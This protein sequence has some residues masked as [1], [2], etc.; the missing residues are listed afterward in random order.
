MS[1]S[2]EPPAEQNTDALAPLLSD[3]LARAQGE[4]KQ[5]RS[6]PEA[7]Y[8]L[9][10]HAGFTFRDAASIVPYLA[11]L[12]ISDCYA[13]PF[14]KAAPGS[15]HG[16]DIT[17][18][19]SLNPEIGTA[20]DLAEL[21]NAL[22][23]HGMGMLLDTVPNHMGILGN[24]NAWWND[25][26]ENGHASP[27]AS[28][29]DIDWS[30]PVRPE[31]RDKVLLALLG[32]SYGE[33]LERGELRVAR[34]GG[35]FHVRYHEHRFPLDPAT[36]GEIL[37]P[38]LEP[39]IAQLGPDHAAVQEIQSVLTAIGHLPRHTEASAG[40]AAERLR[41]KE[42]IKRRLA[43]LIGDHPEIEAAITAALDKLNG[44][45]GSPSSFDALDALLGSQPFRLAFWRVAR[46][47]INYRRFFDVNTLVALRADREDVFRATHSLILDLATRYDVIGLR[48]DHPDGLLDP[49]AYLGRLQS[50]FLLQ[51][52]RKVYQE[53]SE[54]RNATWKEVEPLARDL[55]HSPRENGGFPPAL[56]VVVEK[57][58]G[59][60]EPFPEDWESHGT[61]GYDMLNQISGLFVDQSAE[62]AF[63]R[64]YEEWAGNNAPYTEI[65]RQKKMLILDTLLASELHVLAYQLE[66]IALRDR[67]SRDFTQ[68]A[69]RL[70]L[71]EVIASFPVYRSYITASKVGEQDRVLVN[72]AIR[73]AMRRNPVTSRSIFL[74]LRNVLLGHA[75]ESTN[76][77]DDELA[78]ADFAGK[79]QQVTAPVM[80]KGL[81]DTTFYVYNRLVSLN[82]V[83]GDPGHFGT[84]PQSLHRWNT[85]R[86]QRFPQ[87][88]TPLSTHDTKRSEDVRARIN[89]LSEN[90]ASWFAAVQRWS[91]LNAA[92]RVALEDGEAPDHNEEYFF[93]QNLLGAW[94]IGDLDDAAFG[95]FR[96]RIR[97]YM[98]KALHEAKTHSS[99]QNP[100]PQYDEAVD[101]FV[102]AV[103]DRDRNRPFLDDFLAFER[104][105]QHHGMLN[106]LAQTLLKIT[107]PGVPDT[108]QGTEIWDLSLVDPDNRRPVDYGL[109]SGMLQDLRAALG[110]E[111][112]A[113]DRLVASLLASPADG[114]IK[115]YVHWRA[116]AAR[117][118]APGLFS[119]GEYR[120]LEAQGDR[121]N[122]VFAF[123]RGD[124]SRIALVAVPRLTTSLVQPGQFPL[125]VDVWKS[126]RLQLPV[127]PGTILVDAF[128]G[129][130]V[131]TE[132]AGE[133]ASSL[134]AGTLFAHFPVALLLNWADG[135]G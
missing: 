109:R 111:A 127:A 64:R 123:L 88:L 9:Q 77:P 30:A 129:H 99:W 29:F 107:L 126:T 87:A 81:E 6:A 86:A 113:S 79:F 11:M 50:A 130:R 23:E 72:R 108:Y 78:P 101:K 48:I 46:D 115:L 42:V 27:Y 71:R 54:R 131:A 98:A 39:T 135:K 100:D 22:K 124:Q 18:H 92:H 8:R 43:S 103:L 25:V 85:R 55:I 128:T 66:R 125:G 37:A 104:V 57:I 119:S 28:Y 21:M 80:A 20:D 118:Q 110:N 95:A 70:A 93:Y 73:S 10:L 41:E 3:L 1:S 121:E 132:P 15:M 117:R 106:S 24:E 51:M 56:Y 44:E 5:R 74:F 47:E 32:D 90:P 14:L 13:S 67:R 112:G 40:R 133:T 19:G 83:G 75:G 94:P 105:I 69:L 97:A 36:Y 7:T 63:S 58:L 76:P 122:H 120:P 116:L 60:E 53:T 52:A 26:L 62:R 102:L 17:D 38:A 89:V 114:R 96:E 49:Q 33:V 68:S 65:V 31:N 45:P 134:S 84:A 12:G 59:S 82:E 91:E 4:I 34:E 2:V 16:Y 35:S 61:S